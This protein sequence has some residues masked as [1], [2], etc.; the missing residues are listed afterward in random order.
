MYMYFI[1]IVFIYIFIWV[2]GSLASIFRS[3]S[4]YNSR[5]FKKAGGF[6]FNFRRIYLILKNPRDVQIKSVGKVI[7]TFQILCGA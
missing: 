3:G 5:N 4:R 7:T 2:S 1:V 6:F